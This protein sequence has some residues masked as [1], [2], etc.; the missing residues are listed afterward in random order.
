M[1]TALPQAD[2]SPVPD[3]PVGLFERV[4]DVSALAVLRIVLGLVAVVHLS[5]FL[6]D[7]RAGDYYDDHFWLPYATWVPHP[8]G[9]L[10]ALLLWVGT[11]E[12]AC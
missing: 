10:W 12:R 5:K 4:G 9:E 2:A 11:V 1:T 3:A 6:A 7:A 8:S